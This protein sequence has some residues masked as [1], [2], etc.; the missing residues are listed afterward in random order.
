MRKI[1]LFILLLS[2]L[3]IDAKLIE[4][5]LWEDTYVNEVPVNAETVA[6]LAAGDVLRIYVTVPVGG[7]NFKICY[8][9]ASNGWS[10]TTIPSINTQWPWV[11][12]GET[13]YNFTLTS[14]DITALAGMNI[15]IYKGENSTIDKVSKIVDNPNIVEV[16]IG[17]DGIC[18]WSYDKKLNFAGTGIKAYYASAV[19]Q[20]FVTL[21]ETETTWDWQGYILTGA[22]GSY[23]IP[24]TNE[25]SYPS[26]NYLKQ[27]V[28]AGSVYASTAS[29]YHYI[30][31]KNESGDIGFYKLTADH[32]LAAHKA[33]LETDTDITPAAGVKGVRFIF[34]DDVDGVVSTESER[35]QDEAIY[36]LNGTRVKQPKKGI[37]IMGGR[38]VFVK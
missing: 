20:G 24:V 26:T 5:T 18:T 22:E 7:A 14:E 34:S 27:Q 9:G 6:T 19:S 23:D 13:Y 33:Y 31:A 17:S 1:T 36:T 32:T 4:T 35:N 11:N 21:T 38:T 10:E 8:K 16:S 25:A 15:Y 30:F 2:V 12:G 37:Y 3:N 28:G 29:T